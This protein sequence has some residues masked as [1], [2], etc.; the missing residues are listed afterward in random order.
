[1]EYEQRTTKPKCSRAK[2]PARH[3]PAASRRRSLKP[4]E[5]LSDALA[6]HGCLMPIEDAALLAE[7]LL[8]FAE[9]GLLVSAAGPQAA[10]VETS[11]PSATSGHPSG[12][13]SA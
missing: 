6:Q 7:T 11:D 13:E 9:R 5:A 4:G 8:R 2:K 10:A 3:L 1:M 12:G